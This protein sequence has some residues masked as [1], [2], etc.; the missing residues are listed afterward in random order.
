[1]IVPNGIGTLTQLSPASR[2][3]RCLVRSMCGFSYAADPRRMGRAWVRQRPSHQFREEGRES[4]RRAH[5][6]TS[7]WPELT[8]FVGGNRTCCSAAVVR[9]RSWCGCVRCRNKHRQLAGSL[10]SWILII[11]AASFGD[12]HP[13]AQRVLMGAGNYTCMIRQLRP[14]R[15]VVGRR[16]VWFDRTGIFKHRRL[17]NDS[18][19]KA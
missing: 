15:N 18:G 7:G 11:H 1:L 19:A 6:M 9:A 12:G 10:S 2:W 4:V 3:R 14:N 13:V 8:E 17:V 16:A 5:R